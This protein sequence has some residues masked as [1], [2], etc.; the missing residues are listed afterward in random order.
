[1]VLK[2]HTINHVNQS[3][4]EGADKK[5]LAL[6]TSVI[7]SIVPNAI[8]TLFGSRALNSATPCSDYDIAIDCGERLPF[9]TMSRLRGVLEELPI[10][11]KIDIIDVH[12]TSNEFRTIAL[13]N[14]QQLE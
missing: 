2:Q 4:S 5:V 3:F 1:M 11:Q 10:I 14:S 8:I 12:R 13:S 6:I 9:A 7:H